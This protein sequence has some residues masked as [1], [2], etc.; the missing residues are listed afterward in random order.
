MN[1]RTYIAL[2]TSL[3]AASIATAESTRNTSPE[4]EVYVQ[5]IEISETASASSGISW[6]LDDTGIASLVASDMTNSLRSLTQ[7]DS[8][9]LLSAPSVRTQSGKNATI[10]VV[11]EYIYATA[12]DVRTIS[13]TN[14]ESEV[15]GVAVS[16]DKF[17]TRDVGVTL[18]VTPLFDPERDMIDLKLM[19]EIV[20][21]PSWTPYSATYNGADGTSKTVDISQPVFHTRQI[22]ETLSIRNN[23]TV[24]MGGMITTGK[25]QIDDRVPILGSIPWLGR[26]FRDQREVNKKWTLLIA[27]TAR[28]VSET[29]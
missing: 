23:T 3:I 12:I 9:D 18:D 11:S 10:K 14:A 15:I 22:D 21:E 16:P 2:A 29:Q 20:S 1:M 27:I 26:L 17:V 13:T 5:F 25:I 24:V 28:T 8:V 7:F 4:V 19:A 6:Q